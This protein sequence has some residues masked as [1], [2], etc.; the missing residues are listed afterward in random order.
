[1]MYNCNI[2]EVTPKDH[3]LIVAKEP[4]CF[5]FLRFDLITYLHTNYRYIA[6]FRYIVN[7]IV[8]FRGGA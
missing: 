1:M 5:D 6:T 7:I 2:F 4:P 3:N 8:E